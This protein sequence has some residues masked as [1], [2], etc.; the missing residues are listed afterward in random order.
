MEEKWREKEGIYSDRGH[1]AGY[2]WVGIDA[3]EILER[4][5]IMNKN[6]FVSNNIT[7]VCSIYCI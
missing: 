7:T 2:L 1:K 3:S 5:C 6:K 4:F